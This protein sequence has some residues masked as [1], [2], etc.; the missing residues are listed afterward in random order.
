MTA[1]AESL[2][3]SIPDYAF[4]SF[5]ASLLPGHRIYKPH[6]VAQKAKV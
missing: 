6:A 5:E 3:P 1:I 2:R 4:V